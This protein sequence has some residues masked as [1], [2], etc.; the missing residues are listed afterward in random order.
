MFRWTGDKE[1]LLERA[2]RTPWQ[3]GELAAAVALAAAGVP[4]GEGS[5]RCKGSPG[6]IV[7]TA[8]EQLPGAVDLLTG[9]SLGLM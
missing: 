3:D 7:G 9:R 6:S 4:R 8:V 5:T 2:G 1:G